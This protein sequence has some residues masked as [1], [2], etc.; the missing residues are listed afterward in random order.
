MMECERI[1]ART[2]P[3]FCQPRDAHLSSSR[4]TCRETEVALVVYACDTYALSDKSTS[5]PRMTKER[6]RGSL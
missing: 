5:Y 3:R 4:H 2:S 1:V 6:K